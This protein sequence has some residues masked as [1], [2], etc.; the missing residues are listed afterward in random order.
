MI[1]IEKA[2][3]VKNRISISNNYKAII[4]NSIY[5]AAWKKVIEIEINAFANNYIW[6]KSRRLLNVNIVT[7][8]WVFTVKYAAN[9]AINRY[10]VRL[11]TKEF[12]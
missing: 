5:K 7:F 1:T 2:H 3:G 10:K 9:K 11:I 4:N 6:K 8:K 12:T